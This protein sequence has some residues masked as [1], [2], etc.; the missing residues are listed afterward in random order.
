LIVAFFLAQILGGFMSFNGKSFDASNPRQ[1][2]VDIVTLGLGTID[3]FVKM[4]NDGLSQ[5]AFLAAGAALGIDVEG[6]E[7]TIDSIGRAIGKKIEGESGLTVGNVFDGEA[8]K[9]KLERAGIQLL[10][11]NAGIDGAASR[12]G[13]AA[14]IASKV[15]ARILEAGGAEFAAAVYSGSEVLEVV[16][17]LQG[18]ELK[19]SKAAADSRARQE[20]YRASHKR[21]LA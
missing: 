11:K 4:K 8:L 17:R 19:T 10:M 16:K 13:L 3:A 1:S 18:R 6:G 7:V 12:E 15:R 5:L 14:G 9:I 21:V 2:M 20:K